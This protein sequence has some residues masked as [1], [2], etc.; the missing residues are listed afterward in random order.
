M[1]FTLSVQ[2]YRGLESVEWSPRGVCALAGPNGGGKTTL[3]DVLE[4]LRH[5]YEVNFVRAVE[6]HGG[7][8]GFRR[9]G[10]PKERGVVFG[11]RVENATPWEYRPSFSGPAFSSAELIGIPRERRELR[12]ESDGRLGIRLLADTGGAEAESLRPLVRLLTSYR[13]HRRYSLSDIVEHGSP[14]TSETALSPSGANVFSVLRNWRDQRT[15]RDRSAFVIDSLKSMFPD[16]FADLDFETGPGIVS[17]QV[18][19][20]TFEDAV[21]ARLAPDGWLTALLHLAAVAS[22]E[23]GGVVSIDEPENALHPYA[24]RALLDA[25]RDWSAK[26]DVTILL[27]TH[28]PV[29]LDQFKSAPDRVYIM[30]P[31][32]D[33]LPVSLEK[34]KPAEWLAH[35]SFGDLYTHLKVGAPKRDGAT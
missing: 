10:A 15:F 33:V 26:R 16:F 4:L 34:L 21:P 25:F 22:A 2:N 13:F 30:E 3:L 24:I 32:H 8:Y 31:G 7:A 11:L 14:V 19:T 9:F 1:G 18:V 23:P 35:F 5:A 29:V 28:S 12:P 17:G 20:T 6:H 27:A